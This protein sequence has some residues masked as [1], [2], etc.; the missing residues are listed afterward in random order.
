M[1]RPN[2]P[3]CGS[4]QTRY[5]QKNSKKFE[6]AH[7]CN[8]CGR[9]FSIAFSNTRKKRGFLSKLILTLLGGAAIY[10][11]ITL[12][13]NHITNQNQNS[14]VNTS[15]EEPTISNQEL[16]PLTET[17]EPTQPIPKQEEEKPQTEQNSQTYLIEENNKQKEDQ[18]SIADSQNKDD[19][20][21]IKT[22]LRNKTE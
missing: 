14:S 20:L 2:C 5:S 10:V 4:V 17:I 11:I 15:K 9:Q 21:S 19:T 13:F 6:E 3:Y 18:R 16:K 1:Y 8:N 22:T 7:T 12:I